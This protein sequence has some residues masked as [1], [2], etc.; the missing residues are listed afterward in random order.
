MRNSLI[1]SDFDTPDGI[2]S[3]RPVKRLYEIEKLKTT[4]TCPKL[5]QKHI[6][7]SSFDKMRVRYAVQVFSKKKR[8]IS[9]KMKIKK[10]GQQQNAF[11]KL[12]RFLTV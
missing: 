4:R 9:K 2:V 5:T 11:K 3:F 6:D 7:P 10:L 1:N 12:I 8:T